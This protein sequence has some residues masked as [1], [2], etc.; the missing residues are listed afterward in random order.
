MI[1]F[2]MIQ[3]Q[4]E[5][6]DGYLDHFNLNLQKVEMYGGQYVFCSKYLTEEVN[7]EPTVLYIKS[8]DENFKA[9]LF[10]CCSDD[11]RYGDLLDQ[12]KDGSHLGRYE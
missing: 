9:F 7:D 2:K 5:S 12:I 3:V 1:I 8:E 6:N 11:T 10:V 4:T